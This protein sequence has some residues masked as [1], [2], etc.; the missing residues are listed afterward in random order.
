MLVC[1]CAK[2]NFFKYIV[3]KYEFFCFVYEYA[4]GFKTRSLQSYK[5]LANV[6]VFY[7]C[8][9][10]SFYFFLFRSVFFLLFAFRITQFKF[11][12]LLDNK[13]K[14]RIKFRV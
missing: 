14:I 1:E 4:T 6:I 7:C 9:I 5:A 11:A 13:L 2:V 8:Y 12:F 3:I 10:L